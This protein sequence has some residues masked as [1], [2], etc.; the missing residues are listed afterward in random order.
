LLRTAALA[1][2][3][4]AVEFTSLK[5]Y[6]KLIASIRDHSPYLAWAAE[7]RTPDEIKA[8]TLEILRPHFLNPSVLTS[9]PISVLAHEAVTISNIQ[10]DPWASSMLAGVLSEYREALAQ[11]NPASI[12]AVEAWDEPIARA[13]SEFMSIYL[14]EVDKAELEIDELRLEVLRNVGGLLEACLQP[15]LKALLHHVRIR[16]LQKPQA[17]AIMALTF[18][19]AV[20]EL[21]QTLR[22]PGI[23][24]PPPW[25]IKLHQWRNVAQHHS[26]TIQGDRIQC[27]YR[28]GKAQRHIA[29]TRA[30]F[31]AVARK[32]QEVLGIVRVARSIFVADNAVAL[33]GRRAVEARPKIRFFQ[34]AVGIAAQGFNIVGVDVS[35]NTAHLLVQDTTDQD[36]RL[37]G[38]HASQFLVAAWVHFPKPVVRVTYSD[39]SG[40]TRLE[41][42]AAGRDCEEIAEER[43]PFESLADR[44]TY[45]VVDR[46]KQAR[47]T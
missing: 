11:D 18:G 19:D 40:S 35:D 27:H 39:K 29:L 41:A 47:N 6:E 32:M 25:G 20:E 23:L 9:I 3:Q 34:T 15:Q 43:V 38:I 44:V 17:E 45:R 16:R 33:C 13:M 24:A 5:L 1:D 12:A 8:Q 46:G 10:G 4:R 37:R 22:A 30:E 28:V 7:G 21:L 36:S 14:M 26:A 42:T 31:V 2:E